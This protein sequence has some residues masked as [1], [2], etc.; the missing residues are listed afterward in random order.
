MVSVMRAYCPK[1]GKPLTVF[2][3][4]AKDGK[5]VYHTY[6]EYGHFWDVIVDGKNGVSLKERHKDDFK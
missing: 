2:A 4:D 1:C 3:L 5:T 6:C